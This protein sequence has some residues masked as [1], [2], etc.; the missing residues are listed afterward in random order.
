MKEQHLYFY[1]FNDVCM[2]LHNSWE[3]KTILDVHF[4]NIW[5]ERKKRFNDKKEGSL[6]VDRLSEP[7]LALKWVWH[8]PC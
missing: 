4:L 5:I 7:N 3:R 2:S 6:L 8:V 1:I